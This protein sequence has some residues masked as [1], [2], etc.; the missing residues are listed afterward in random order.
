MKKVLLIAL[1][2]LTSCVKENATESEKVEKNQ[3]DIKTLTEHLIVIDFDEGDVEGLTEY[4]IRRFNSEGSA[5]QNSYYM[6][7]P[8]GFYKIGDTL[9]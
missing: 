1:L 3:N 4:E 8:K 7:K 9:Q 2:A 5:T 6:Q